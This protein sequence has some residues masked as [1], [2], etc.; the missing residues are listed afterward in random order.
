VLRRTDSPASAIFD[1]TPSKMADDRKRIANSSARAS[2]LFRTIS[3]DP[4]KATAIGVQVRL[5]RPQR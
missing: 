4:A 2:Q 1:G 5:G 3:T